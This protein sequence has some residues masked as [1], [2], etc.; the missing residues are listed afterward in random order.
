MARPYLPTT[1]PM[2]F[3]EDF[4]PDSEEEE[5]TTKCCQY[6]RSRLKH[7]RDRPRDSSTIIEFVQIS[8]EGQQQSKSNTVS[9]VSSPLL[10]RKHPENV[11]NNRKV[12]SGYEASNGGQSRATPSSPAPLPRDPHGVSP[13]TRTI[14]YHEDLGATYV[15]IPQPPHVVTR[16]RESVAH[17]L[18]PRDESILSLCEFERKYEQERGLYQSNGSMSLS[19]H[20]LLSPPSED[21]SLSTMNSSGFKFKTQLLSRYSIE[22]EEE[23]RMLKQLIR[24]V[25]NSYLYTSCFS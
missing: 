12:V 1:L 9:A 8:K 2:E 25:L 10:S 24:D 11:K 22:L 20:S 16:R 3:V 13:R 19:S 4:G 15:G 21:I 14:V 23:N 18:I 5:S 6:P 17:P 7:K